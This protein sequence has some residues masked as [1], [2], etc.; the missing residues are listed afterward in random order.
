MGGLKDILKFKKGFKDWNTT[1]TVKINCEYTSELEKVIT[2][3]E[4]Y[5]PEKLKSVIIPWRA[6]EPFLRG[7]TTPYADGTGLDI[8]AKGG[9]IDVRDGKGFMIEIREDQV[10]SILIA[11]SRLQEEISP[12]VQKLK[13]DY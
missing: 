7:Q 1:F 6:F 11:C 9:S 5:L 10:N 12:S 3:I 13:D 2:T 4:F 8:S